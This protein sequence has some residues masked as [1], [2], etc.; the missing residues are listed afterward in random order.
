MAKKSK[1]PADRAKTSE[2]FINGLVSVGIYHTNPKLVIEIPGTY[3]EAAVNDVQNA[4][5]EVLKNHGH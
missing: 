5:D 3:S 4:V 2:A 1:Y